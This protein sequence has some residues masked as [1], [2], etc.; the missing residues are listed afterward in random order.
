ME[1]QGSVGRKWRKEFDE[2]GE[3]GVRE[4]LFR[5]AF[6]ANQRK[7]GFACR[8]LEEKRKEQEKEKHDRKQWIVF[9]L[10][11][12]LGLLAAAGLGEFW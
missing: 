2:M 10:L 7:E 5:G 1:G 12:I 9:I 11:A 6:Q 3:A 8:W 4:E